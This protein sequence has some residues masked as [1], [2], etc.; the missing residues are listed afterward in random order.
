MKV[1]KEVRVRKRQPKQ[2]MVS[3]KT[4]KKHEKTGVFESKYPHSPE[5][6]KRKSERFPQETINLL[7]SYILDHML[8]HIEIPTPGPHEREL[9]MRQTGKSDGQIAQWFARSKRKLNTKRVR[10]LLKKELGMDLYVPP[11]ITANFPSWGDFPKSIHDIETRCEGSIVGKRRK[12]QWKITST[13]MTMLKKIKKEIPNL[14]S[15]KIDAICKI[16]RL[17]ID[18]IHQHLKI[19]PEETPLQPL[20]YQVLRNA[21]LN[22][23]P[24]DSQSLGIIAKCTRLSLERISFWMAK[25]PTSKLSEDDRQKAEDELIQSA[26]KLFRGRADEMKR[27]N[28]RLHFMM[29]ESFKALGSN[30]LT[31]PRKFNARYHHSSAR[32]PLGSMPI[33]PPPILS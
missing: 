30:P 26:R 5:R 3:G 22:Q 6:R 18:I 13:Q 21:R 28:P 1:K 2:T 16:T 33:L 10:E 9:L 31:F 29:R 27:E 11:N 25:F 24:D 15:R 14:D 7:G 17:P 8:V 19:P 32:R 4:R 20:Q 12:K 23:F